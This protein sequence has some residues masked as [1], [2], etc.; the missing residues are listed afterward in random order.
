MRRFNIPM[1]ELGYIKPAYFETRG[2]YASSSQ[3]LKEQAFPALMSGPFANMTDGEMSAYAWKNM[4]NEK[5]LEFP[6]V[7]DF[8]C[9][10]MG[11]EG[12]EF[13]RSLFG[14][15][16]AYGMEQST[17]FTYEHS[18][19]KKHYFSYEYLR[20]VGG[21]SDITTALENSAKR[22]GVKMYLNEK[23]KALNREENTFNIYTEKFS[24]SAKKLIIAVPTFPFEEIDG[25]VA[26]E[27]KS[28]SLFK[29][30][31]ARPSFK[32]AAIYSYPWWANA[33]SSHNI[34]LKPFEMFTTGSTCLVDMMPYR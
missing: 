3:S 24:V 14:G 29:A 22:L 19:A 26:M 27:I 9:Q 34:T 28:N 8:M 15:K 20:P 10:R 5:A 4:S 16:V 11:F 33:T 7:E 12:C 30:I 17:L 32:A 25:D 6:S 18:Q 23:V 1:F 31:L 21:L 2:F 13:L